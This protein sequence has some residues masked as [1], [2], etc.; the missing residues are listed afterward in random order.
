MPLARPSANTLAARRY[1]E[2]K[3]QGVP[4]WKWKVGKVQE[5]FHFHEQLTSEKPEYT[6]E[7]DSDYDNPGLTLRPQATSETSPRVHVCSQADEGDQG[8]EDCT[9]PAHQDDLETDHDQDDDGDQGGPVQEDG[10]TPAGQDDP[11][12]GQDQAD[13]G[14]EGGRVHEGANRGEDD[15]DDPGDDSSSSS[16]S[17]GEGGGGRRGRDFRR[18]REARLHQGDEEELF[19]NIGSFLLQLHSQFQVSHSS[20]CNT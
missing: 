11:G 13:Q 14:E 3:R 10:A 9:T 17:D 19:D 1:R 16:D 8:Q 18:Y 2:R 7:S 15:P 20:F 6:I 12:E 5:D 4:R